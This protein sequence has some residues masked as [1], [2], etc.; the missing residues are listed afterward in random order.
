[1]TA[2]RCILFAIWEG[3]KPQP[4]LKRRLFLEEEESDEIHL[5]SLQGWMDSWGKFPSLRSGVRLHPVQ[6]II[7]DSVV[8]PDLLS[9][10]SGRETVAADP[11]GH[12]GGRVFRCPKGHSFTLPVT[13]DEA[14]RRLAEMG[15]EVGQ[16]HQSTRIET[17]RDADTKKLCQEATVL[18]PATTGSG[19]CL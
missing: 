7:G 5:S 11:S 4:K 10:A 18:G 16:Y 1:M 6:Q 15:S 9:E 3:G 17:L 19:G 13:R 12:L 2:D 14:H 8:L